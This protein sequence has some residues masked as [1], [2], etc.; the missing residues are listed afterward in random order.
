MFR[1]VCCAAALAALSACAGAPSQG[2]RPAQAP[3]TAGQY[4]FSGFV[5]GVGTVT[6]RMDVDAAG[7]AA[8]SRAVVACPSLAVREGASL[9]CGVRTVRLAAAASP[10]RARVVLS[11]TERTTSAEG[12]Y[13]REPAGAA[14]TR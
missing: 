11:V 10:Q 8:P 3:A 1:R 7:V 4:D 9:S 14:P 2:A 6:G 12:C 5:P 13:L